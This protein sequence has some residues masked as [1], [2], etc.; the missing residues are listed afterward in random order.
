M[1]SH[2]AALGLHGLLFG[3]AAFVIVGSLRTVRDLPPA[4]LLAL[5][6]AVIALAGYVSFWCWFVA[7]W[8]GWVFDG[9]W[10]LA[11]IGT[12]VARWR[13]LVALARQPDLYFP[14]GLLVAVG[15]LH[16]GVLHL[17]TTDLP[18][19]RLAAHR[20]VANLPPD[21]EIPRL[22]A[23]RLVAGESPRQLIGDWLS[24][25]RPPLQTGVILL[26]APLAAGLGL[27][28]TESAHA[29]AW[30][31]QAL[32][33]CAFWALFR[34]A[35]LD[36]FA[37]VSLVAILA[38]SG[39]TLL[40][41]LYLWPKLGAAALVVMTWLL[42]NAPPPATM[43]RAIA[44]G[45][46]AGLAWLAHGSAAFS[47]LGLGLVVVL[48]RRAPLPAVTLAALAFAL[49]AA[50][51]VTYQKVYEPPG[52]RLL[53]WHLAGVIP[54]DPRRF[55]ETLWTAYESLSAQEVMANKLANVRR[56]LQVRPSEWWDP[57]PTRSESRRISHFY[58]LLQAISPWILAWCWWPWWWW[59]R[60]GEAMEVGWLLVWTAATVVIWA[61]LMFGPGTTLIH[62]GSLV[63]PLVAI[64]S[65]AV[66]LH[67]VQRWWLLP[68]A[69]WQLYHFVTTWLPASHRTE[70][71][72]VW[73]AAFGLGLG[74]TA[75]GM[76]GWRSRR[77]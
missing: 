13:P 11:V 18:L 54:P 60:R 71:P 38:L 35:R 53:K 5:A 34:M 41:G 31:L 1:I 21:N 37:S 46:C 27:P 43:I 73:T 62:Q 6:G 29:A 17:F 10:W 19:D 49:L 26:T 56:L 16:L 4:L 12:A 22:F 61:G 3:I 15:L 68:L 70:G 36:L 55:G 28:W 45:G 30:W 66:I 14:A 74:L 32:W 8:C 58:D 51:W 50:P 47:L 24:S 69:L 40:H 9:L 42:W 59:R 44:A 2:A 48:A 33:V 57:Q 67:Q 76:L 39:Q 65:A 77:E 7:P 75:L 25:D 23:E 63:V 64:A 52:D 72:V 20:F